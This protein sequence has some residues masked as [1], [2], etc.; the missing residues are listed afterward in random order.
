MSARIAY[1]ALFVILLPA[2]LAAWAQ[3]L[4]VLVWLPLPPDRLASPAV[5]LTIAASGLLMMLA[6]MRDLWRFGHGLPASPFPPKRLVTRGVYRLVAD[7]IYVGSVT[8]G[9]GVSLW[10]RSP[11][12]LWIVTPI[13]ALAIAAFV[14]GHERDATRRRFGATTAPWLRLPSVADD[15]PTIAERVS[16]YALVFAPWLVLY[17]SIEYL[18]APPDA[19]STYFAWD[20]S[21][22]VVPWTESMYAAT[23]LFVLAAPLV[24]RRRR[25]LAELAR[26]GLTATAMIIPIYLLVPLVA[27]AKPVVGSGLWRAMLEWERLGDSPATAFPSFHVV[28]ACLAARMY[29]STIARLRWLWWSIAAAMCVAAVTTGLHSGADVVAGLV[30]YVVVTRRRAIW[31]FLRGA[32]EHVANSWRESNVGPV[33]LI[34]HGI[35]AGLGATFSIG[36]SIALAGVGQLA[37]FAACVFGAVAGAA[38]WGQLVE[39]SS[40]LLRP[41][42]Y[43]GSVA[44]VVI[45]S[46]IA[47]AAGADAWLVFTAF[48]VGSTITSAFGRLR[49]LVQGCCHGRAAPS[50][51]GIRFTH[52]RSRVVRLSTLGGVPVHPTQLYA[53]IS[54][55]FVGC[56]LVRLWVLAAPLSLIAG[57]Y[58]VLTGISRFVEEHFRGEPQ[59]ATVA[60]LRL[61]QWLAIGFVIGGAVLTTIRTSP[62]PAPHPIDLAALPVLALVGLLT[63]AAY[64]MDFPAS[65]WRFSRLT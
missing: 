27:T 25:D 48:G 56:V 22:P 36:L 58:F 49:C 14:H 29:S 60:G 65:G 44:G 31:A 28:W 53:I 43:F 8:V 32:A 50:S 64:G 23:Y 61:Y 34:N 24:A 10:A 37:W 12:G 16:V 57:V 55:L 26:S 17:Q 11:A 59:T 38:L 51:I 63:Y 40:A 15:R 30:A 62:A 19:R 3:R 1:A 18:G 45:V 47:G 2:A 7:P 4:D 13:F 52:P 35:Y 41:Y 46:S 20:A 42:G 9:A 54:A 6:G 21:L 5:G 33:R 39:G